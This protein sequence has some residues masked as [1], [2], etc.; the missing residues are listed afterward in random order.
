MKS[1]KQLCIPR[2]SV[3]DPT[4]RDTVLNLTHLI[5]GKIDAKCFFEENYVT[6]G[7]RTLLTESFRRLEGKSE[8]AV[9]KLTQAMGGGKTHNLITLGLLAKHPESRADVLGACRQ[10]K[11]CRTVS[12][13]WLSRGARPMFRMGSGAKSRSRSEKKSS[14]RRTTHPSRRPVAPH[15]QSA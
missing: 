12:G 9:F 14:S 13:R 8:Q 6:E 7:M 4:K 3:F 15:G 10:P 1:L 11:L 5:D 2:D